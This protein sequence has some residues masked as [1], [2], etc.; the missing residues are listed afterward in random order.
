M[1]NWIIGR[2]GAPLSKLVSICVCFDDFQD[3]FLII[4][5]DLVA[6]LVCWL[7]SGE[8]FIFKF[9]VIF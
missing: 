5:H 6:K 1:V 3:D 7:I 4:N 9:A 2:R 8:L